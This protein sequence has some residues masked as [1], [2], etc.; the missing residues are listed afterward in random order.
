MQVEV[1]HGAGLSSMRSARTTAC[2]AGSPESDDKM[3]RGFLGE[4]SV[5]LNGFA[6]QQI[7]QLNTSKCVQEIVRSELNQTSTDS[8]DLCEVLYFAKRAPLPKHAFRGCM[9]LPPYDA[10]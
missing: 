3:F 2:I 9:N 1:I 5:L 4:V 10:V 8:D 6:G 7:R